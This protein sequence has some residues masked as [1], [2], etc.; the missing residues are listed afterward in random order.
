MDTF[1]SDKSERGV[2]NFWEKRESASQQWNSS[3]HFYPIP[4]G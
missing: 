2:S 1:I 4:I 3:V